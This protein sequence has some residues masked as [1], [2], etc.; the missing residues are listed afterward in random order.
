MRYLINV[1]PLSEYVYERNW[2]TV[3]ILNQRKVAVEFQTG[4][5]CK[6]KLEKENQDFNLVIAKLIQV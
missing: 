4:K 6:Q 3:E 1:T 5:L 2:L